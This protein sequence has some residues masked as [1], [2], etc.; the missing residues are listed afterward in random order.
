MTDSITRRDFIQGVAVTATVPLLPGLASAAEESPYPPALTGLRGSH[1]G[2]FE[3]AHALAMAGDRSW[4]PVRWSDEVYDLVVVGAGLSGLSAAWFFRKQRPDA[5]ILILDNHDDFGGHAKR[6][7]FDVDGRTLISYGGSQTIDRPKAYSRG[8]SKLLKELGIDLSALKTAYD[9]NFFRRHE[10]GQ[11]IYFDKASY[12]EDRLLRSDF[13]RGLKTYLPLAETGIS[14][15]QAIPRMPLSL[16]ARDEF[17]RVVQ[18]RD[19]QM[20]GGLFRNARQLGEMSYLDYLQD[21]LE[22]REPAVIDFWFRLLSPLYGYGIDKI[23]ASEALLAGAPGIGGSS[24]RKID[25]IAKGVINHYPAYVHHFPSGNAGIARLMVA[26]LV[27]SAGDATSMQAA[28]TSRFDYSQLDLPGAQV[29]VRLN[30]MAMHVEQRDN[31]V[32]ITTLRGGQAEGVRAKSC[33]L[34]GYN[35]LAPHICPSLPAPQK[36][37]LSSLVKIPLVYTKV[38]VRNWRPWKEAGIGHAHSPRSY[39]QSVE[40]EMPVSL[41]DYQYSA[42]PDDPVVLHMVRV[43]HHPGLPIADQLRAG[44]WELLQTPFGRFEA[45][46]RTHLGGMLGPFGF[47]ADR[48]IAGITVNRWPHGYAYSFDSVEDEPYPRGEAPYEIGRQAFERISIANSDAGGRAYADAAIDQG[49][50]AAREVLEWV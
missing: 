13:F 42:S 18:L 17:L 21:V 45:E 44:R 27:P 3:S 28:V 11:G 50:R 7:E 39:H 16:A 6:N 26:G 12:G 38:A 47:D 22:V 43:P 5:R 30:T 34:A 40:L 46:V 41:G 36:Q 29:R 25:W 14:L 15:E 2:A 32:A 48:D 20:P 23:R 24:L 1:P 31:V 8:A 35:M 10:L 9:R 33:I 37:A 4:G 49:H 19:D